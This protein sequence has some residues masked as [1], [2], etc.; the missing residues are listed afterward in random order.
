MALTYDYTSL[1]GADSFTGIEHKETSQFAWV[2]VAIDMNE[3]TKENVDEVVFRLLFA[4]QC[5]QNFLIGDFTKD[6]LKTLIKTYME[7]YLLSDEKYLLS[8]DSLNINQTFLEIFIGKLALNEDAMLTK[9]YNK[10]RHYHYTNN[11][12]YKKELEKIENVLFKVTDN[13]GIGVDSNYRFNYYNYYFGVTIDELED[14]VKM[15]NLPEYFLENYKKYFVKY[16][17]F[18]NKDYTFC[19]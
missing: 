5:N 4:K 18:G 16:E 1:A 11:G 10:K 13:I 8:K 19:I 17:Y 15:K 7:T 12:G 9:N 3:V 2:L 14:F 6:S